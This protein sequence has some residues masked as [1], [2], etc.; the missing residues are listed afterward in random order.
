MRR[1]GVSLPHPVRV[2][3]APPGSAGL[4]RA[5]PAADRGRPVQAR[6][7]ADADE[8]EAEGLDP[9]EHAEERRL[10]AELTGEDGLDRDVDGEVLERREDGLA[11]P[12]LDADLVALGAH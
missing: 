5:R 4:A 1:A 12:S 10:V 11:Q 2:K 6:E 9:S 8:L 3:S 7:P